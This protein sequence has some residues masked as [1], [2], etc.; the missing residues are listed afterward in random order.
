MRSQITVYHNPRCSKSREALEILKQN[1]VD[2]IVVNYIKTPPLRA[3]IDAIL[4]KL[5]LRPKDVLRRKEAVF[6]ELGLQDK[7]EDDEEIVRA[8]CANPI[9]LE[10]PIAISGDTAVIARPPEKILELLKAA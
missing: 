10:R 3:E 6:T 7:L 9:L 2:P 4:N 1:G 5:N 8:I